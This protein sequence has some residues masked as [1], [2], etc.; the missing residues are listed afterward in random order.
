MRN[1][2]SVKFLGRI[3]RNSTFTIICPIFIGLIFKIPKLP[4]KS[5]IV[6]DCG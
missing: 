4:K 2:K 3:E 6:D 5:H 1:F